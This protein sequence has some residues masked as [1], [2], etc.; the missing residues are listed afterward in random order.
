MVL[1]RRLA[2]RLSDRSLDKSFETIIKN[3]LDQIISEKGDIDSQAAI[4]FSL[5][6]NP[7]VIKLGLKV[8]PNLLVGS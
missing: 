4:I 2:N 1:F 5:L 8:L 7:S 6:S 3:N